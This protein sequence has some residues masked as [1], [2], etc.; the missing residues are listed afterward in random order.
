MTELVP[1]EHLTD[2]VPGRILLASDALNWRHVALRAYH[3]HAQDVIVPA[4]RDFML[5]SYQ[6]GVTPM[7]RTFGG[8]WTHNK[9]QPGATSLLTRAQRAHWTW[10]E[11]IDVTHIYLSGAIV[12][13]VASEVMDA[14]VSDVRLADILRTDDPMMAAAAQY[15]SEEARQQGMGGALYV[16]SIARA[17]IV[18]LLRRYASVKLSR[19]AAA[20][21]LGPAQKRRIEDYIRSNLSASLDLTGMAAELGLTP[22]LF[23]RLF[24]KSFGTPPYQYVIEMRLARASHL[25]ARTGM[26]IKEI[27]AICGFA[28]QAH[29]TRLFSRAF[30]TT[31]AAFRR[32]VQS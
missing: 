31:P 27:V 6:V 14:H 12:A 2:W 23:S 29:L 26:P 25:L 1:P 20:Q 15:L 19:P 22:C 5:V 4:M 8:R 32:E 16:E 17:L 13:N 21:E 10:S 18:H 7:Q 30:S 3:Y 28:D 24:R 9:L 11:P